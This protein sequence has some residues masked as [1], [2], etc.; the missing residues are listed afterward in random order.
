MTTEADLGTVIDI[1]IGGTFTDCFVRRATGDSTAVKT[2]T[3]GFRLAVGFRQGLEE[4][5]KRF[6]L[7]ISELLLETSTIRYSTTVAMNTLLQRSG[8]KL[9]LVTT[10]GFEDVLDIAR[11]AAWMDAAVVREIR[12]VAR[13]TK[14][15]PLVK[16]EMIL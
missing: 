2:P 11:G 16:A 7:T 12:N 3:T 1:D 15:D 4:A 13:I 9:C 10:A 6:G 5:A 14:P 8:P